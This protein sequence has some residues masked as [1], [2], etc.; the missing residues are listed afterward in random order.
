MGIE[1]NSW[2]K[3]SP[4]SKERSRKK[5]RTGGENVEIEGIGVGIGEEV[6]GRSIGCERR[7][8]KTKRDPTSRATPANGISTAKKKEK[9]RRKVSMEDDSSEKGTDS[10]GKKTS[11]K[12]GNVAQLV[13]HLPCMQGVT[14][15]TL[16]ISKRAES[17]RKIGKRLLS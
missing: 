16:V 7:G 3:S 4:S 13:V 1:S 8:E 15:S 17:G 2:R 12:N 14:S 9:K 5:N 6:R 11:R 10:V